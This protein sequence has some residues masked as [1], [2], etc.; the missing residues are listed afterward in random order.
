MG[1]TGL[2]PLLSAEGRS[3]R[4][5]AADGALGALVDE[6]HGEV[7][8]LD[9]GLLVCQAVTQPDLAD[10]GFSEPARVAK[11]TLERCSNLL[12][13]GATP[14]GVTDGKPPAEKLERL[15][16]RGAAPRN[17]QKYVGST[18]W[19]ATVTWPRPTDG[20]PRHGTLHLVG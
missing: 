19:H 18:D 9:L 12:R 7:V 3:N 20:S 15:V 2:W 10:V 13:F 6:L 16:Q 17:A 14:V 8:T 1:V 4:H 5:V 11:L